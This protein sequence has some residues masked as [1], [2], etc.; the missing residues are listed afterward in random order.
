MLLNPSPKDRVLSHFPKHKDGIEEMTE[1]WSVAGPR[2]KCNPL[3]SRTKL[4]LASHGRQF[5]NEAQET[6]LLYW[7]IHTKLQVSFMGNRSKQL[8]WEP[9]LMALS[10]CP[11]HSQKFCHSKIN[12]WDESSLLIMH[13][14]LRQSTPQVFDPLFCIHCSG[15]V[16]PIAGDAS[17]HFGHPG[18]V[19]YP[20]GQAQVEGH[21]W[22]HKTQSYTVARTIEGVDKGLQST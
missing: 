22:A 21:S 8:L 11:A 14:H 12:Q 18:S 5:I 9:W 17:Y 15:M 10:H 6:T 20:R 13:L 3:V 19:H 1:S 16:A 7:I 4:W 2:K